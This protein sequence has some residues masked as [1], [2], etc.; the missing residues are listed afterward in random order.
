MKPGLGSEY[1]KDQMQ[2]GWKI[3]IISGGSAATYLGDQLQKEMYY[4]H[5][6]DIWEIW[7]IGMLCVFFH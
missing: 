7:E 3:H 6:Q 4:N 1:I 2:A 5:I